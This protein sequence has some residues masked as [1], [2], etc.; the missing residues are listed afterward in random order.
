MSQGTEC[1][2]LGVVRGTPSPSVDKLSSFV[3]VAREKGGA[4]LQLASVNASCVFLTGAG[5]EATLGLW[6]N[7]IALKEPGSKLNL[8]RVSSGL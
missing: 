8:W 7:S 1:S 6:Q 5:R 4:E 3:R 2:S